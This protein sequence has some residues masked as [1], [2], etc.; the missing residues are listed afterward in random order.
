VNKV[1]Q[2]PSQREIDVFMAGKSTFQRPASPDPELRLFSVKAAPAVSPKPLP[3]SSSIAP[4]S[5]TSHRAR[6]T[7]S[8]STTSAKRQR[9]PSPPTRR[10]GKLVNI[11]PSQPAPS[12][13][14]SRERASNESQHHQVPF[15]SEPRSLSPPPILPDLQNLQKA[16]VPPTR[17]VGPF[18]E[19]RDTVL[20]THPDPLRGHF[21]KTPGAWYE[22][23]S[24]FPMPRR[25]WGRSDSF[26]PPPGPNRHLEPTRE[27]FKS[28]RGA[29]DEELRIN[30]YYWVGNSFIDLFLLVF[31]R[32]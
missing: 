23:R 13:G 24:H 10:H 25:H 5:I 20:F 3:V 7:T 22:T 29:N 32:I 19:G 2:E 4:S 9:S 16:H 15:Q 27:S 28:P 14:R 1:Q 31:F 30:Q 18:D 21:V 6:F 12:R 26:S 17:A 11:A 8:D